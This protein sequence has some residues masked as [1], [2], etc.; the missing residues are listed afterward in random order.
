MVMA[1]VAIQMVIDWNGCT[2]QLACEIIVAWIGG[3]ENPIQGRPW[4]IWRRVCTMWRSSWSTEGFKLG[5]SSSQ[6]VLVKLILALVWIL[7]LF[8]F[9]WAL[10]LCSLIF[11][12]VLFIFWASQTCTSSGFRYSCT[13]VR[14]GIGIRES[15]QEL[16]QRFLP[17]MMLALVLY[18]SFAPRTEYLRASAVVL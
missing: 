8:Q 17:R 9:W 2:L 6:L 11:V 3:V 16:R 10:L 12:L 18:G 5:W 1:L 7:I 4:R 15:S 14:G 13:V